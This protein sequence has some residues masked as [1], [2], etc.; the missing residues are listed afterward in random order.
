MRARW[1]LLPSMKP[2]TRL[3]ATPL[4]VPESSSKAMSRR[5]REKP[6]EKNLDANSAKRLTVTVLTAPFWVTRSYKRLRAFGSGGYSATQLGHRTTPQAGN[7][8]FADTARPRRRGDRITACP[9]V[10]LFGR[11]RSC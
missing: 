6:F 11:K 5:G 2:T 4:R 7:L 3:K 1:P 8:R 9:F 10:A